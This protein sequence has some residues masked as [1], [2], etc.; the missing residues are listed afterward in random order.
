MASK[1]YAINVN[2]AAIDKVT[3]VVAGIGNKTIKTLHNIENA[4]QRTT[5]RMN[6]A[7]KSMASSPLGA[8][9][10][11]LA[12]VASYDALKNTLEKCSEAA[13]AEAKIQRELNARM[14]TVPGQTMATVHTYEA[15]AEKMERIYKVNHKVTESLGSVLSGAHLQEKTLEKIAPGLLGYAQFVTKKVNPSMEEMATVTKGVLKAF[16]G[17][18]G[19]LMRAGIPLT[20]TQKKIL[21]LGTEMQKADLIAT[22][23]KNQGFVTILGGNARSQGGQEADVQ[24]RIERLQVKIGGPL[25]RLKLTWL[26]TFDHMLPALNNMV[27]RGAPKLE[28]LVTS[29][30]RLV[31]RTITWAEKNPEAA[32]TIAKIVGVVT[33]LLVFAGPIGKIAGVIASVVGWVIKLGPPIMA[34]IE[35]FTTFGVSIEAIIALVTPIGWVVIAVAALAGVAYLVYRNWDRIK[36]WF[37]GFWKWMHGA[38]PLAKMLQW[39]PMVKMAT[40]IIDNWDTLKAWFLKLPG[41]LQGVWKSITGNENFQKFMTVQGWI[42][43]RTLATLAGKGIAKGASAAGNWLVTGPNVPTGRSAMRGGGTDSKLH[44]KIDAPKG[45][46]VDSSKLAPGHSLS[47]KHGV[48]GAA[49][50]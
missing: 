2:I 32:K 5:G 27:D 8:V 36:K 6:R 11:V 14:L 31:N 38:S 1:A 22:K 26:K 34:T 21:K 49:F 12:T 17:V 7:F 24:N 30:D 44:I 35:W 20:E 37:V 41:V 42:S 29:I 4:A 3:K 47:M 40:L 15:Y 25:N 28:K 13:R 9:G 18:P 39:I 45:T 50:G 16:N 33:A 43:G 46:K 19:G 23:F 48:S 10:G